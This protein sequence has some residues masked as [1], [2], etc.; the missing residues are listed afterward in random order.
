VIRWL[1]YSLYRVEWIRRYLRT[2]PPDSGIAG[3]MTPGMWEWRR[4]CIE[5]NRGFLGPVRESQSV[6][7][8]RWPFNEHDARVR[9]ECERQ[10]TNLRALGYTFPVVSRP[11]SED[12]WRAWGERE[13]HR[14][15]RYTWA[16]G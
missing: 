12:D 8:W 9:R 6:G 5:W 7:D 3:Y 13:R 11:M 1:W 16:R 10:S 2:P 15:L 4:D 14:A